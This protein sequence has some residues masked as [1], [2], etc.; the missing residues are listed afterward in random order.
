MISIVIP[1]Y[2]EE[3]RIASTLL[4]LDAHLKGIPHEIIVVFDGSDQTPAEVSSLHLLNTRVVVFPN[5]MGKGAAISQ[6]FRLS[7]GNVVVMCDADGSMP[8]SELPKL[9]GALKTHDVA[10]GNRYSHQAKARISFA[11]EVTAWFFNRWACFLFNLSYPDTQCGYKAF[12]SKAAKKLAEK[13]KQKGFVWDVEMLAL[14]KKFGFSVAS[15]PV[16]WRE[17]G[18][19]V[20]SKNTFSTGL[21]IFWDTL[22]LRFQF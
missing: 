16:V 7:L 13:T 5:R 11:R 2:N 9:L 3:K 22:K 15:V 6:G 17:K 12:S 20:V 21:S 14:C 18:G 4:N 8:A 10:I 19:G 1:A